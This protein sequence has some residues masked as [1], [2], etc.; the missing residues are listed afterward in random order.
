[1]AH[2][3]VESRPRNA[4]LGVLNRLGGH[5]TPRSAYGNCTEGRRYPPSLTVC[6]QP[7]LI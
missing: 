6:H 3:E 4:R 5:F 2:G 1:M 7:H